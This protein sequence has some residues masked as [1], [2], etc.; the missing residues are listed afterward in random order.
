MRSLMHPARMAATVIA[1][2]LLSM[3]TVPRAWGHCDTLDGPIAPEAQRALESGDVTPILKWVKAPDEPEIREAFRQSREIR[4]QGEAVREMADRYFLE[5]LIRIHRQ[6]EGAPYTGLKP[7]GSA[8]PAFAAADLALETGDVERIADEMAG[9]V[10]AAITTRFAE[11]RERRDH[12]GESVD[13]GREYVEAYV[14]Y[15]HFVEGLHTY[16][17]DRVAPHGDPSPGSHTD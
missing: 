15:L 12:A 1:L 7:A 2:A 13:A 17:N 10:R 16:L 3:V 8:D 6:G 9:A 14:T 11:A 5:T 4:G